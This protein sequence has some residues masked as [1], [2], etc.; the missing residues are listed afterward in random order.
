MTPRPNSIG[1]NDRRIVAKANLDTR[2]AIG[3][4]WWTD[5][6]YSPQDADTKFRIAQ[7]EA[8]VLEKRIK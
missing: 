3:A 8:S 5:R 1:M 4:K 6:G 2:I 7:S